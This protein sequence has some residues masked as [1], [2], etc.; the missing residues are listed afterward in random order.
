MFTYFETLAANVISKI[1]P[2]SFDKFESKYFAKPTDDQ[3]LFSML[4]QRSKN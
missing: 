4:E 3:D 1:V 2:F